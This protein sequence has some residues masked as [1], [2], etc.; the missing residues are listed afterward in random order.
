MGILDEDYDIWTGKKRKKSKGNNYNGGILG[1]VP[2]IWD[3]PKNSR[4]NSLN[5]N[6]W[7]K[8]PNEQ[9]TNNDRPLPKSVRE[10]VWIRYIGNSMVGKCYVCRRAI[11]HD[12][13]Q[14]GHVISR[15]NGGGDTPEN[16]RPICGSCNRGM[17]TKN[18]KEYAKKYYG[19]NI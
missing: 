17:G 14:A 8:Q 2:S 1:S 13:F 18:M 5:F 10:N 15:A 7:N 16:L 4:K 12:H 3:N 9:K 19:R 11:T 6:L